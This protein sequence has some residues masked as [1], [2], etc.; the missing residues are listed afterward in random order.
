ML[1]PQISNEREWRYR[2]EGGGREREEVRGR[3]EGKGLIHLLL[4]QAHTAVAANADREIDTLLL[5]YNA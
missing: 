4:P 2:E 3:E 5:F 1:C